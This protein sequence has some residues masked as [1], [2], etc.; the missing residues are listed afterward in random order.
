[1]QHTLKRLAMRRP[2]GGAQLELHLA[3]CET[4]I[5]IQLL[6][7]TIKPRRRHFQPFVVGVFHRQHVQ[8][9][10]RDLLAILHRDAGDG[11]PIHSLVLREVD[12]HAHE[13][14][15]RL[16]EIDQFVAHALDRFFNQIA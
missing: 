5:I 8:Q 1:M 2:H 9:L 11:T 12:E 16:L 7:R 13:P 10:M 3:A 6:E 4:H 14:T 15:A